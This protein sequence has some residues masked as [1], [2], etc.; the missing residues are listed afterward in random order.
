MEDKKVNSRVSQKEVREM[1]D[2]EVLFVL[3][4]P[5]GA[6]L[7]QFVVGVGKHFF[8]VIVVITSP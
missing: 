5:F 6:S 3:L 4:L 2:K 8:S 1:E 7:H